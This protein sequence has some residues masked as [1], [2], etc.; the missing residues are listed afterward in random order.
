MQWY[1]ES[2]SN[3]DRE[4]MINIASVPFIIGR[5]DDSNLKLADQR[6]SRYHSEIRISGDFL[7]IRDLKSTNGTFVN[8]NKIEQAQLLEPNDILSIGKYKF[9]IQSISSSSPDTDSETICETLSEQLTDLDLSSFEP[10]IQE[11]LSG[12]NVIP[13]FQPLLRFSDMTKLGYEI[14]GR[15]TDERLPSNP[16]ELL[17][18]AQCL[19][20]GSELSAL[21][22]EVGVKIG[23]N[24]PGSPLLFVNSTKFELHEIDKLLVSMK[25]ISDISPSNKVVLEINEKAA[26]GANDLNILRDSLEKIEIGLAFD[27]FGVGQTRLVEL[28]NTPPD[29]LKF[30]ISLVRK[31]HLA[32][33]RLHQMISTFIK[34]SHDLGILTLAEGVECSDEAQIC[35][36]LGF[37]IGQ[38]YFFGRPAAIHELSR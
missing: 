7:W 11:L 29:Y 8:Q 15:V 25:K 24:L 34:A 6:I 1:L 30:D 5:A 38:G 32:P 19:G 12:R 2:L 10:T 35:Q 23:K 36:Q 28:S 9:R 33:K 14:L 16:A 4:W 22:R 37:D 13:H 3:S 20:Y 17:D 27:D 21:F 26:A 18:I 31:I